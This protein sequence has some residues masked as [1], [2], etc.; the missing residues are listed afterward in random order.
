MRQEGNVLRLR[1]IVEKASMQAH[2]TTPLHHYTLPEGV[3]E[4][5]CERNEQISSSH[6]AICTKCN[7]GD[8]TIRRTGYVVLTLLVY[9]Y[10]WVC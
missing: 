6:L 5:V 10:T 9:C 3:D 4:P 7:F 8:T 2:A 1:V